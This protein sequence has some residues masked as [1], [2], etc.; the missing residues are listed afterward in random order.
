MKIFQL[1]KTFALENCKIPLDNY[2]KLTHNYKDPTNDNHN[3]LN[4]KRNK[5]LYNSSDS[6]DYKFMTHHSNNN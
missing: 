5:R 4:I 6:D 2:N 1:S 3:N